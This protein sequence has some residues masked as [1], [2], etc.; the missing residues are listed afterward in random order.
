MSPEPSQ[1]E[2][3]GEDGLRRELNSALGLIERHEAALRNISLL[4]H[5]DP[6]DG[7]GTSGE[8]VFQFVKRNLDDWNNDVLLKALVRAFG[9]SDP[10]YVH[11][12][13]HVENA[14]H[15]IQSNLSVERQMN[16]ELRLKL[17]HMMIN[18]KVELARAKESVSNQ[19]LVQLREVLKRAQRIWIRN[20]VSDSPTG[21][22]AALIMGITEELEKAEVE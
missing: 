22:F 20:A 9:W 12:Y 5:T 13:L 6:S 14:V 11:A 4:F 21:I 3:M 8:E 2:M 18:H 19:P 15:N 1:I 17:E 16:E 10:S 7:E